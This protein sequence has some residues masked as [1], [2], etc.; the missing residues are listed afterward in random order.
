[1]KFLAAQEDKRKRRRTNSNQKMEQEKGEE[2]VFHNLY[3]PS[4][5]VHCD[6]C[7]KEITKQARVQ[8]VDCPLQVDIC[9][10]CFLNLQAFG[11]HTPQHRY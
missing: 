7:E 1:M 9:V 2:S 5:R 4:N 3:Y 10:N 6:S 8:C 11:Q